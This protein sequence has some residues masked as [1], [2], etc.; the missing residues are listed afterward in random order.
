MKKKLAKVAVEF[1]HVNVQIVKNIRLLKIINPL[2]RIKEIIDLFLAKFPK[3]RFIND[4][5]DFLYISI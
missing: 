2:N 1:L 5:K 4:I 3:I